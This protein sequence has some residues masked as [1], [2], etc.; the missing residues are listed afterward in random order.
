MPD[1]PENSAF[2]LLSSPKTLVMATADKNGAPNVSMR[3][4]CAVR[5]AIRVHEF[6]FAPH[7]KHDGNGKGECYVHRRRSAD[8]K[9]LCTKA[10]DS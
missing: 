7:N 5:R 4:S 6:P 2:K 8:K 3:H 1:K 9:L 10:C